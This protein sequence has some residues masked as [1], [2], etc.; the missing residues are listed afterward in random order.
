MDSLIC[1]FNH[2]KIFEDEQLDTLR[3]LD[4]DLSRFQNKYLNPMKDTR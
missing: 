3:N 1:D 2:L 4:I